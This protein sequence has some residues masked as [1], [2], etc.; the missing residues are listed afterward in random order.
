VPNEKERLIM[1]RELVLRRIAELKRLAFGSTRLT[2]E[3]GGECFSLVLLTEDQASDTR[4]M[5]LLSAWRRMHEQW[6]PATFKVTIEG[7]ALWY[8]AGVIDAPDRL[9]FIV[10]GPGGYLGHVG[11]FRFDFSD[12]TC[13][14][15]NIVRGN[16]GLPGV[17]GP[18]IAMMMA[19]GEREF[20]I[21]GFRLQTFADNE[22]ALRLYER[23]GFRETA[24]NPLARKQSGE[25]VEWLEG[26]DVPG[27]VV[28]YNVH[29]LRRVS[30]D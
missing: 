1:D 15:D 4:L 11:L 3:H 22:R 26:Q 13:E 28:R 16:R 24:R 30:D 18:A 8:R 27:A 7:T 6:F 9:L 21:Q 19:W 2:G 29:M 10:E 14:I 20:G 12:G 17:M 25:R 5:E 23:L